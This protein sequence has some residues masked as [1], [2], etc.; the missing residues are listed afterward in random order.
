MNIHK[1]AIIGENAV[2]GK[3]VKIGAYSIIEDGVEIGDGCEIGRYV[4]IKRGTKMGE[5][6]RIY[7]GAIIGG[8]PQ[9]I[10][11]KSSKSFVKIGSD[12][13]IR[14][15]VTI[16]RA[17]GEGKETTIG[18]GNFLMAYCHIGHDVKIGNGVIIANATQ[19]SGFVRVYDY[20]FLS[21]LC[22][23]H[24]FVRIGSYSIIG[25]GY[26]IPKDVLPYSLSAGDPLRVRGI[27]IVGLKRH[28][29]DKDTI[30][31]IKR[32]FG[33]LLSKELNTH[34]AIQK[35]KKEVPQIDEIKEIITFIESSERGVAL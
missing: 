10:G 18:N 9:D 15:F 2:I 29:F 5:N 22:P 25:G 24:Q 11:F 17:A 31:I 16:H 8:E 20:A 35:I 12:N 4:C 28:N 27:N 33:I 7:E 6:N 1:T 21:G 30:D 14:E 32:A 26:R 13:I 3:R 34:Q 19:L 23:V